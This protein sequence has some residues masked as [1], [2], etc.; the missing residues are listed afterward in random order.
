[1]AEEAMN[2]PMNCI[3]P[4]LATA[5]L[6]AAPQNTAE[7]PAIPNAL[8]AAAVT[9]VDDG[10]CLRVSAG[11]RPILVYHHEVVESPA[12]LDPVYRRSGQIHPL[13][14]PLGKIVTDDFAPDHAHQHGLFFAWVNSTFAGHAV[15]FWNQPGKTGRVR[16]LEILSTESGSAYGGFRVRLLHEDVTKPD[17]PKPVLDEVWTV[18][19]GAAEGC[20]IIDF[21]SVQT[22]VAPEPLT[23]NKYHYGG[24]ALRGNRAWF[25]SGARG[26]NAPDPSRSGRSKFLT[27]DGK[28]RSSGNHTRPRWVDLSG[29]VEGEFAGVAILDHPGN[30]RFPQPVRLHPNKPYFSF[31]PMVLDAFDIAPGRPYVSRYRLIVHDGPPDSKTIDEQ[32]REFARPAAGR[33]VK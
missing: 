26:E 4:A 16:H 8:A 11:E 30:F 12:G 25:D 14:T 28:D 15:D 22:C 3:I 33:I 10:R 7:P 20:H 27:S 19:A 5:L 13:Y 6:T 2:R 17:E 23:L 9:C 1:M 32:W 24:F 29:Q 31:S 18:R 21:E